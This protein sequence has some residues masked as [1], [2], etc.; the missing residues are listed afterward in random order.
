MFGVN[1][2][3]DANFPTRATCD[4]I[5]VDDTHRVYLTMLNGSLDQEARVRLRAF[6]QD[7]GAEVVDATFK[8]APGA[9][10]TMSSPRSSNP[11]FQTNFEGMVSLSTDNAAG[12]FALVRT[13]TLDAMGHVQSVAV[14]M[15]R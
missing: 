12:V 6:A 14:Y 7:N 9:M 8:L 10:Q 5:R 13:S 3:A 11:L 1:A 2:V 15:C 4:D